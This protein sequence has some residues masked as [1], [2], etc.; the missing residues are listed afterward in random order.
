MTLTSA[1]S[2]SA[3]VAHFPCL[4]SLQTTAAVAATEYP[5]TTVWYP[6]WRIGGTNVPAGAMTVTNVTQEYVTYSDASSL[7][8]LPTRDIV[9]WRSVTAAGNETATTGTAR[10]YTLDIQSGSFRPKAFCG[11]YSVNAGTITGPPTASFSMPAT[12]VATQ[13][14]VGI[15]SEGN[16][17]L[18]DQMQ[19]Y[20]PVSDTYAPAPSYTITHVADS[21]GGATSLNLRGWLI[22]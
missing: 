9:N 8:G 17:I 7:P 1:P 22:Y 6:S 20:E 11:L 14:I 13:A 12:D 10:T 3:A 19:I 4:P 2:L 21:L 15:F 18:A 5:Q 16:V